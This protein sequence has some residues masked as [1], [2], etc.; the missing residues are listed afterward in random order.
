MLFKKK[1]LR[2]CQI[3]PHYFW[4]IKTKK[5]G[6]INLSGANGKLKKIVGNRAIVEFDDYGTQTVPTSLVLI[7]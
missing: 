6:I 7:K 3:S 1:P 4:F 2:K 5:F